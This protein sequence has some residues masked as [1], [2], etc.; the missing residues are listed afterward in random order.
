MSSKHYGLDGSVYGVQKVA[1]EGVL[2]KG[3]EEKTIKGP[4]TYTPMA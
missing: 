4:I 2:W 1:E 3:I